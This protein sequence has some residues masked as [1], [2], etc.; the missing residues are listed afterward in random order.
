MGFYIEKSNLT[1][2]EGTLFLKSD[3]GHC[4]SL[5][6]VKYLLS[7]PDFRKNNA[8]LILIFSKAADMMKRGEVGAVELFDYD[9]E[10]N[11]EKAH[12]TQSGKLV[13]IIY[14]REAGGFPLDLPD[15]EQSLEDPDFIKKNP[16]LI[17][18]FKKALQMIER[19][20]V[21]RVIV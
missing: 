3:D 14:L 12:R 9:M 13:P 18:I 16:H 20:E 1:T 15:I 19:G 8:H 2:L 17:P 6:S 4:H 11:V 21:G 10:F 7:S 5:E